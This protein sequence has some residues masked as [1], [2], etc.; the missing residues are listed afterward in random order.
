MQERHPVLMTERLLLKCLSD[1]EFSA[2]SE[3]LL[4]KCEVVLNKTRKKHPSV[5]CPLD[6]Q[7][8]QRLTCYVEHFILAV[9]TVGKGWKSYEL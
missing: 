9:A 8:P 7:C 6:L 4:S 1:P 2:H 3:Q 5:C